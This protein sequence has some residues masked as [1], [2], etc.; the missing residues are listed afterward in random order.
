MDLG[1]GIGYDWWEWWWDKVSGLFVD[2]DEEIRIGESILGGEGK[3]GD[4]ENVCGFL[5]MVWIGL[6]LLRLIW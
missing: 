1:I 5:D 2:C 4:V 3:K 6:F